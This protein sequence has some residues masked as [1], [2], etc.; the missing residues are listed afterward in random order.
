MPSKSAKNIPGKRPFS[1]DFSGNSKTDPS[2]TPACDVNN[3]VKTYA[4]EKITLGSPEDPYYSRVQH[5]DQGEATE[6]SYESAMRAKAEIDSAFALLPSPLREQYDNDS[7]AWFE[8][9]I[10]PK[11]LSEP[12]NGSTDSP[13]DPPP[14]AAKPGKSESEAE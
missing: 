12:Q 7:T 8:A 1:Q 4:R 3:I 14:E 10:E 6:L 5:G 2:F 13:V 11:P 9:T